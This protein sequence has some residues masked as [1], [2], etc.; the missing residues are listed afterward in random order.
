MIKIKEILIKI[1]GGYTKEELWEAQNIAEEKANGKLLEYKAIA[2]ENLK[3]A[4]YERDQRKSLSRL[5]SNTVNKNK[6]LRR[7]KNFYQTKAEAY[8]SDVIN[9][10]SYIKRKGSKANV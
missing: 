2:D 3:M 5:Y 9:F 4:E 1:L 10:K 7:E 8:Q 6:S